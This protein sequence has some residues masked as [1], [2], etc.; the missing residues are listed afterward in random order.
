MRDRGPQP[1]VRRLRAGDVCGYR[2]GH[3]PDRQDPPEDVLEPVIHLLHRGRTGTAHPS[4]RRSTGSTQAP[5]WSPRQATMATSSSKMRTSGE[6]TTVGNRP[7][8]R[9]STG[10]EAHPAAATPAGTPAPFTPSN[11]AMGRRDRRGRKSCEHV[12]D[13]VSQRGRSRQATCVEGHEERSTDGR[14]GAAPS[15]RQHWSVESSQ[16]RRSGARCPAR[17]G[18]RSWKRPE[19]RAIAA[20][21]P[22]HVARAHGARET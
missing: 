3:C 13:R 16:Q 2:E 14:R 17:P 6:R 19:G 10:S 11:G 20:P 7:G 1:A 8:Q 9:R 18:T 15:P 12:R 22:A 4:R 21:G 5:L